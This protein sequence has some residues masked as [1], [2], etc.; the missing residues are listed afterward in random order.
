[1]LEDPGSALISGK[2]IH[3]VSILT[4]EHRAYRAK[5]VSFQVTLGAQ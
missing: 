3:I 5:L 2:Y 1:M 4:L